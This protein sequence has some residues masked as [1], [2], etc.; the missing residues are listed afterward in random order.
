MSPDGTY[1]T[2]LEALEARGYR[3]DRHQPFRFFR[4]VPVDDVKIVVEVDF[5]AG[6]YG[7]TGSA[8]RTQRVQDI[9]ARKARGCDLVFSDP[10]EMKLDTILK[11]TLP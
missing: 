9:R 8:R 10:V 5:L 6:E 11:S 2:A 3:Q 4:E 7:G 1:H